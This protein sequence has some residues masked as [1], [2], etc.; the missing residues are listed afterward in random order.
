MKRV[1]VVKGNHDGILGVY[2]NVK[3]AFDRAKEYFGD[4][5]FDMTYSNVVKAC[6][7]WGCTMY[8]LDSE[9]SVEIEVFYLNK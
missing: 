9:T 2:T 4:N 5:E 7:G 3:W 1:L 8:S 6:K